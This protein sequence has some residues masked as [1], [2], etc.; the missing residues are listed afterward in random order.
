[1]KKIRHI[2]SLFFLLLACLPALTS[3]EEDW[4]DG[5]GDM[6]GQWR[7]VETTNYNIYRQGDR[8]YFLP[9]GEFRT[10]GYDGMNEYGN[11][12]RTGRSLYLYFNNYSY[13]EIEAY[14]R[15]YSGDYMVLDV[16]DYYNGTSYTLRLVRESY[17]NY[18]QHKQLH[19]GGNE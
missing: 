6:D 17:Y 10:E 5:R 1:M 16:Q 2:F 18:S 12:E 19:D 13:P 8:W 14:V 4:W 15:D 9:N 3:C 11:W 7:V